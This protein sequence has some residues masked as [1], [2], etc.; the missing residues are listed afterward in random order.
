[1][2]AI[3]T[4][5]EAAATQHRL[6]QALGPEGR[7]ALALSMSELAREFAKAGLRNR[8]PEYAGDELLRELTNELH[9]RTVD[10]R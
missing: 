6:H 7:F 3:D 8:H 2:R 1:M 10:R 5:A 9:G 4:S